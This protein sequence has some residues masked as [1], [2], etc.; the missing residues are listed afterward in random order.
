MATLI[1]SFV[2]YSSAAR[3]GSTFTFAAETNAAASDDV[4]TGFLLPSPPQDGYTNYLTGK[5]LADK[6]PVGA[7]INGITIEVEAQSTDEQDRT[8]IVDDSVRLYQNNALAGEDKADGTQTLVSLSDLPYSFGS[9]SALWGLTWI[10]GD[11]S[12][13]TD[14][15][16]TGFGAAIS[17]LIDQSG[18]GGNGEAA[19]DHLLV[20]IDYTAAATARGKS[21]PL[22]GS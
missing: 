13:A 5:E 17:F 15:N 4:R 18:S 21:L 3:V 9:S 11:G 14:I 22:L 20:S 10:A 16:G 6:V 12:G 1:T 8:V 2:T 7:T 19:V